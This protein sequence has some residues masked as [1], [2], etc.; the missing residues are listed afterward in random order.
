MEST[1]VESVCW[2]ASLGAAPAEAVLAKARAENPGVVVQLFKAD[3]AP[4]P[5]ALELVA[6]QTL[7]AAAAGTTLADKPE[8]DLLLR[9][10][11]TRQ[12]GE[13]FEVAGY[14]SGARRLFLLAASEGTGSL[15]GMKASLGGDARF[16]EVPRRELSEEDLDLVE[17]AALLAVG[18]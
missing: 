8:L 7:A 10:S 12:I 5:A 11:G 3:S 4:N 9:L 14:R 15:R 18:T 13:A 2:E 1:V 16:S 6:A 17:R